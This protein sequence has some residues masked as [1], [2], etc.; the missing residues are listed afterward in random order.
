MELLYT[1]EISDA[2]HFL[3]TTTMPH[4]D[5]YK[6]HNA[7]IDYKGELFFMTNFF[8]VFWTSIKNLLSV[9]HTFLV[10][11]MFKNYLR[12]I[13]SLDMCVTDDCVACFNSAALALH[14]NFEFIIPQIKVG[15]FYIIKK[16]IFRSYIAEIRLMFGPG[17]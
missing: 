4:N 5:I 1:G 2:H 17:I 16:F 3:F 14:T 12:Q 8:L 6:S 15:L 13:L 10:G 11:N 7:D 9:A